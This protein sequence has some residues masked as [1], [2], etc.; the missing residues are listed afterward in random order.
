MYSQRDRAVAFLTLMPSIALIG[1][2]VYGFTPSN[3]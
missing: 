2:F 1:I 3:H